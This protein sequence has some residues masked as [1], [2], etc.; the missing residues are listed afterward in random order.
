MTM[1]HE[2]VIKRVFLKQIVG[3]YSFC[4]EKVGKSSFSREGVN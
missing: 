1:G 3:W 2:E 4:N